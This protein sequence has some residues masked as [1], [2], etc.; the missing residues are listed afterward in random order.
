MRRERPP[1]GLAGSLR[2]RI[3]GIGRRTTHGYELAAPVRRATLLFAHA[4]KVVRERHHWLRGQVRKQVR[5]VFAAELA[6]LPEAE[7]RERFEALAALLSAAYWDELRTHQR[8]SV[9]AARRSL[10]QALH[11][12][13]CAAPSEGQ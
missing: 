1:L 3:G 5:R 4:S 11:A 13:L 9:P 7:R 12:I 6:A 2:E 8:L 10:E